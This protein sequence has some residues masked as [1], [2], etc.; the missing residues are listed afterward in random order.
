MEIWWAVNFV[1]LTK[2]SFD[3][4]WSLSWLMFPSM[5]L[6]DSCWFI[7]FAILIITKRIFPLTIDFEISRCFLL[8]LA[9]YVLA[10]KCSSRLKYNRWWLR[11]HGPSLKYC[12]PWV[13]AEFKCHSLP[14]YGSLN[15]AKLLM[16]S[17][18]CPNQRWKSWRHCLPGSFLD[19]SM[20][21]IMD[22]LVL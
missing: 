12:G 9:Y 6:R 15:V 21:L 20:W 10:R 7:P 1:I 4:L 18:R 13:Q 5:G 3:C 19:H 22:G 14:D 17:S 11:D 2:V 16:I 8:D